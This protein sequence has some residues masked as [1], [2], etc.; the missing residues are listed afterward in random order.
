MPETPSPSEFKSF[1]SSMG[2]QSGEQVTGE[3]QKEFEAYKERRAPLLAE[4]DR[5]VKM[6]GDIGVNMAKIQAPKAPTLQDIPPAPDSEYRDPMQALG[7][8]A[9]VMA[10]LGSM[11][12]RAPLTAAL[13]SA[14]SAMAGFHAGDQERVKLEREKWKDNLYKGLQQNQLEMQRYMNA[15]QEANFDLNKAQQAFR[16]IAAENDH[17]SMKMA[18]ETGD[19]QAQMAILD[20]GL[21]SNHEAAKLWLTDQEKQAQI[22]ATKSFREA[23]LA[24]RKTDKNRAESFK[25]RAEYQKRIGDVD[26]SISGLDEAETLLRGASPGEKLMGSRKLQ[27]VIGGSQRLKLDASQLQNF[28]DIMQRLEGFVSKGIWGELTDAQYQQLLSGLKNLRDKEQAR[29]DSIEQ[30]ARNTA[31]AADLDVGIVFGESGETPSTPGPGSSGGG[32][33]DLDYFLGKP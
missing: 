1:L 22:E 9:S 5:L 18:I 14:A 15:L 30:D 19:F 24:S 33:K 27:H 8:I 20:A 17:V 23:L 10:A 16:M 4:Q 25:L 7:S 26:K 12:T 6:M 28:G 29:R 2:M 3:R 11:K 32:D 13:N 31:K 21:K